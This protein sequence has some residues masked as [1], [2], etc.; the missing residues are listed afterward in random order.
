MHTP[1]RQELLDFTIHVVSLIR[2]IVEAIARHDRE[3]GS[4]V[5]RATNSFALNLAEAF[6]TQNG[7]ERQRLSTALGSV[8]EARHG[9]RLG[10]WGYV[11]AG[12]SAEALAALDRLGGRSV[13]YTHLTLPTILRV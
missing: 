10:A 8:Y 12:E 1:I 3:L 11:D 6:G 5:R 4:Q 7:N 13:S 9:V 2:P